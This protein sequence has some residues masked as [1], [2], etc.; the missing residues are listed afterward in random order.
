MIDGKIAGRVMENQEE[1]RK[2]V[3]NRIAMF[4]SCDSFEG[5]YGGTFGID[6]KTYLEKYRNDFVWEYAEGLRGCGHE[7]FIY[8]LS[9]GP[10]ELHRISERL[11]VRFLPL[12]YWLRA[13]DPFLFRIRNLRHGSSVRDRIAYLGYG[14]ALQG[15]LREDRIDMLY[16][17]EIWTARFDIVVEHTTVPVIGADHGAVF[18]G[19]QEPAKRRSFKR[20]ACLICQSHTGMER[21]RSFG[22]SAVLMSNGVDT[23]FFVPPALPQLR[24]KRIL[25]VGRL[26][27]EQK[28][29][30]DLLQAM[31]SL[32]DFTLTLVGSGPDDGKLKKLAVE[33]ELAERVNFAGFVSDRQEL[34][35]LYQEC[36]AF[37][38]TSSWEAV[39]LV[40]LE[41][42]SCAAPV[43][44]TR[45]PS[46]EELLTHGNDG[47]LVPVGVPEEVAQAIRVA[48]TSQKQ[49]GANA[50]HT[51]ETRYSS[52]VLYSQLSNLIETIKPADRSG[53]DGGSPVRLATHK[54]NER[55]AR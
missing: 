40:M 3:L 39:A 18:A 19:W 53:V 20:A 37:V 12:P 54:P 55:A 45:I 13:V 49:L 27:E 7:V 42:M 28:R 4:T 21:A 22:G 52:G 6:R 34:R 36:G 48:H 26:V 23:T 1:V 16:H 46:F 15:A 41:A 8:I 14:K 17:Q 29:F 25:A 5:F 31:R 44:A 10:P 47:L 2:P 24:A 50:R 33:L 9:Y 51:V 11:F 38:S 43:V 35:R 30:S 32:P